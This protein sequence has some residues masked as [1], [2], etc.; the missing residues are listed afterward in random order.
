MGI[1]DACSVHYMNISSTLLV[2]RKHIYKQCHTMCEDFLDAHSM[3]KANSLCYTVKSILFHH[4]LNIHI[5]Y[6]TMFQLCEEGGHPGH[7]HYTNVCKTLPCRRRAS[8]MPTLQHSWLCGNLWMCVRGHPGCPCSNIPGW[9]GICGCLWEGITKQE[10]FWDRVHVAPLSY[11][12]S[13]ILIQNL[14]L[15]LICT[16]LL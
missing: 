4:I 6:M 3:H 2:N 8:Q 11:F 13:W 16:C 10:L 7:P 12:N 1:L 14:I 15:M 5:V 9:V